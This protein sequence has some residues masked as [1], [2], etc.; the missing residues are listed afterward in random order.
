MKTNSLPENLCT[1]ELIFLRKK[2]M[3]RPTM[4]QKQREA[5]GTQTELHDFVRV[6]IVSPPTRRRCWG[7]WERSYILALGTISLKLSNLPAWEVLSLVNVAKSFSSMM[8]RKSSA[9]KPSPLN[10]EATVERISWTV[11]YILSAVHSKRNSNLLHAAYVVAWSLNVFWWRLR[12]RH[13]R[14]KQINTCTN[15]SQCHEL[16]SQAA[17]GIAPLSCNWYSKKPWL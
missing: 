12:E 13:E 6:S 8:R 5:L 15:I 11:L 9:D 4:R 1:F 10:A 3:D 2:C 16:S 7:F 17:D 14:R